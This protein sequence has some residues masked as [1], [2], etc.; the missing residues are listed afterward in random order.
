LGEEWQTVQGAMAGAERIF[1]TLAL[2]PH[3]SRSERPAPTEIGEPSVRLNAVR[4][5]YAE[6]RPVLH[7]I[8]LE[9]Q[10]GEHVALVGQTGAGKTSVLHLLAGLYLPWS[11]S[12]SVA[13]RDPASL[14]ESER[15]R[16]LG[17]VP[18]MVQL[19]SGTVLENLTL[20]DEA[21]SEEQVYEAT[22]LAGAD[23]FIQALPHGYETLL[24]GH[25]SGAGM[26]LSAGQEQ[27][28]ALARALVHRPL[29][30][31]FDEATAA[32]DGAS[33]ASFRAALRQSVLRRR[34]AALTVAHRLS[35]AME[36]DRIIVLDRGRIVEQGT[37]VELATAGGR[38]AALMELEAAGWNWRTNP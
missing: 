28:L 20:G 37:P 36:T 4:F 2:H 21:V 3:S 16:L 35:T 6:E 1:G 29:V 24:G 10:P 18:Q 34:S 13:G 9:V 7:G 19:F 38:F 27:L 30:L 5:G 22:R 32:I 33:D 15:S 11:G 17:V 8:S 31:L 12:I 23:T 26:R 14:D 25:G